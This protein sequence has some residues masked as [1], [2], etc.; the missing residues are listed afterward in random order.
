MVNRT[1]AEIKTNNMRTVCGWPRVVKV[2]VYWGEFIEMFGTKQSRL[3]M[4]NE[5]ARTELSDMILL[6]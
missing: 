1:A 5:R 2:H 3:D 4:M 6:Q